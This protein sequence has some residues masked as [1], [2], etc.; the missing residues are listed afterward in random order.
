[1]AEVKKF[2][3]SFLDTVR[4]ERNDIRQFWLR[5]T[6]K[7]VLAVLLVEQA[8]RLVMYRGTNM[9][10]SMPTGSLCAERSVIGAAFAS[11]P[12]LRREDLRMVAVLA[13]PLPFDELGPAPPSLIP[14]SPYLER[15]N[16]RKI[17]I[18]FPKLESTSLLSEESKLTLS[19]RR[20]VTRSMSVGSF[21]SI[22]ESDDFLVSHDD[23]SSLVLVS[24]DRPL[25]D[26]A[27]ALMKH[28]KSALIPRETKEQ[29]YSGKDISLVPSSTGTVNPM[30]R[31]K[32]YADADET[33]LHSPSLQVSNN[34]PKR[35]QKRTV[36]VHFSDDLNPLRPCGA[37]KYAATLTGFIHHVISILYP[38]SIKFL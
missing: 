25:E 9:E 30:R 2:R 8:G 28:K 37:C 5:K 23:D 31:I 10:V 1:V 3:E 6:K 27:S 36:L 20:E 38:T 13:V 24:S 15:G 14:S 11:N 21:A 33:Q 22:V 26:S 12:G 16:S 19:E 29:D 18:G 35:K 32:L 4:N 7:P 34:A 17:S